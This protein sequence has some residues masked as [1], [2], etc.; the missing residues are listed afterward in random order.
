MIIRSLDSNHDF[1]FGRGLQDYLRDNK[2]IM[3]NIDTRINSFLNNCFFDMNA[4]IDWIRLLSRKSTKEELK[5]SVRRVILGST[6]VV[7]INN[8]EVELLEG[9]GV[10]ITYDIDTIYT[11]RFTQNLEV[12]NA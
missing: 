7:Q 1:N 12:L 9:R 2:A 8:L 3:L 10:K 4:G 11:K 5:L 6:G